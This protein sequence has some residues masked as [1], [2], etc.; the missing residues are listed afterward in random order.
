[1]AKDASGPRNRAT[2]LGLCADCTFSRAIESPRGSTFYLCE[3]SRADP[4]FPR[5]PTLPVL[6]CTGHVP[7]NATSNAERE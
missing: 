4:A 1:M 3:R 5:Y 6:R 2:P 7:T